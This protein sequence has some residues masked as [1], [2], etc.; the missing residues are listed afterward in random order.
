MVAIHIICGCSHLAVGSHFIWITVGDAR[1]RNQKYWIPVIILL[2]LMSGCM[3]PQEERLQLDQLPQHV[4]RVQSAVELYWKEKKV[5]PYKYEKDEIKFTSKSTVDFKKL[6]GYL[7]QIPPTAFEEGG[8]F[9][10]VL[11]NVEE[12]PIVRLFDLRLNDQV[13]KVQIMVRDYLQKNKKLPTQE[14][15]DAQFFTIDYQKLSIDE[16]KVPSPYDPQAT[17]P[18]V[19]NDKGKVLI[20]YRAEAMKMIQKAK[21]QPSEQ[22]D[23]RLWMSKQ[24][25]YVPAF[26]I[27]MKFEKGTPRFTSF[28]E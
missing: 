1:M 28:E 18:L 4:S 20:D 10:Y 23:L 9:L 19:V 13:E 27:P 15:V 5:L 24:S 2:S 14:K 25:L 16:P 6:G 11:T 12:K 21:K 8:Y 17:L 7:D 3:Y 26:S 22:E